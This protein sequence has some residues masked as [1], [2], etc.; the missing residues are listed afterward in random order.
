LVLTTT[1]GTKALLRAADAERALV[2]ASYPVRG[3]RRRGVAGR[4]VACWSVRRVSFA[5][6]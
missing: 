6:S 5:G 1:N 4:Y 2:A 3:D